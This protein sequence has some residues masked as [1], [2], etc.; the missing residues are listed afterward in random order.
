MAKQHLDRLRLTTLVT[1]TALLMGVVPIRAMGNTHSIKIDPNDAIPVAIKPQI[2]G[3]NNSWNTVRRG[4]FERFF[5]SGFRNLDPERNIGANL[6][7][8]PGG[9]DAEFHDWPRSNTIRAI[10]RTKKESEK[11]ENPDEDHI[12]WIEFTWGKNKRPTPT[13]EDVLVRQVRDIENSA[14]ME[15]GQTV[16]ISP[17]AHPASVTESLFNVS[18]A[19]LYV[20]P[21]LEYICYP[22]ADNLTAVTERAAAIVGNHKHVFKRWE[23][24]NEWFLARKCPGSRNDLR[25]NY[26]RIA[27][28][29]TKKL[30]G[31]SRNPGIRLYL[32]GDWNTIGV[33]KPNETSPAR[34]K[35]NCSN[36]RSSGEHA[37]DDFRYFKKYFSRS[38]DLNTSNYW[39]HVAGVTVHVYTGTD[40]KALFEEI[41]DEDGNTETIKV[42]DKPCAIDKVRPK[43]QAL[44]KRI[45]QSKEIIASEWAP[46]LRHNESDEYFA[47]ANNQIDLLNAILRGGVR[48]AAYWPATQSIP[49]LALLRHPDYDVTPTGRIFK[50]LSDTLVGRQS[51]KSSWEDGGPSA[52]AVRNTTGDRL[53][54]FIQGHGYGS[55]NVRLVIQHRNDG[56]AYNKVQQA[57]VWYK[58]RPHDAIVDEEDP[59]NSDPIQHS[60]YRSTGLA[61]AFLDTVEVENDNHRTIVRFKINPGGNDRGDS[62]EIVRL[63]IDLE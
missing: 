18:R 3:I 47:A 8:Y 59:L 20:L 29:I 17:G 45:G 36:V 61:D 54:I 35:F 19:G 11:A 55:R 6:L 10:R 5:E 32:T 37:T 34:D 13:D 41:E 52:L 16:W 56:H 46:S 50:V 7:R 58:E 25:E 23:V 60:R 26:A 57:D 22:N 51:V 31:N 63:R 48:A 4:D 12:P 24:G 27:L 2:F 38:N 15:N 33:T 39:P 42:R 49:G 9:W 53:L 14:Y 40:P 21:T 1:A 43:L 30:K 44:Q 62:H 28:A